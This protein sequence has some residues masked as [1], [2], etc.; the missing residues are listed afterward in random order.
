MGAYEFTYNYFGDCEGDDCD[1]D[2]PDFAVFAA[3]WQQTACGTCGNADFN[4]DNQVALDDLLII[5]SNWL[6]GK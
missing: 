3:N 6:L 2:L 1:V 4:H 5:T